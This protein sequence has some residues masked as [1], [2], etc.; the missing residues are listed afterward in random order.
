MSRFIFGIF[1]PA[2]FGSDFCRYAA[3][4]NIISLKRRVP[5]VR[6]LIF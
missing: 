5:M 2:A 1:I 6:A 3:S 4:N